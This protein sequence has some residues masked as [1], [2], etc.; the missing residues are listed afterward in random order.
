MSFKN[1]QFNFENI[2]PWLTLLAISW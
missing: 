2:R 1:L